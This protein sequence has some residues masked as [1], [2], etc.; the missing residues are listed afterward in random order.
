M[1][2]ATV[3]CIGEMIGYKQVTGK[4]KSDAGVV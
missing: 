3:C 1:F 4:L 2:M